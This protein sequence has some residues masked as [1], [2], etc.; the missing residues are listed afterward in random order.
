MLQNT[1]F[2]LH[3]VTFLPNKPLSDQKVFFFQNCKNKPL[4]WSFWLTEWVLQIYADFI[5][6]SAFKSV[7]TCVHVLDSSV[8]LGLHDF[9]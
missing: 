4:C 8:M 2:F 3:Y 1:D 5:S 9:I 7:L 6:A